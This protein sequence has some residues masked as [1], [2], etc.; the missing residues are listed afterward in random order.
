MELTIRRGT[1]EIGGTCIEISTAKTRLLV[2]FGMPLVNSK[3]EP[4]V[5]DNFK[6]F[7]VDELINQG[8][9]PNIQGAYSNQEPLVNGLLLSHAHADHF[10]L[11]HYLHPQIPVWLGEASHSILEINRIFLQR[12]TIIKNPNYFNS[13]KPFFIGDSKITPYLNDHSA[14]D[15]YSFLIEA[16]GKK[17]FYSGDFRGHGRKE[18][19]YRW[20]L[21]NTPKDVDY[22]LVEG[23]T[24]G[25]K[26]KNQL[27]EDD[28]EDELRS[29]F[30]KSE[31]INYIYTSSQNI[32]RLVSIYKA[33]SKAQKTFVVDIYTANV[34][35][36]LARFSKLPTPLKGFNNVKVLYPYR[37]TTKL[38]KQGLGDRA[39][40]F[41]SHKIQK[42]EISANP[43]KYV[44][45][46]R[47]SMD[48]DINKIDATHGNLIYS[49]WQGYKD[50]PST[51]R[52]LNML[53]S[54][55]FCIIDLHTS[56]HADISTLVEYADKIS[57]RVIIPIHTFYK[58]DYSSIFK[59][60]VL[61]LND[62]EV[63]TL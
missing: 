57:P 33:C 13:N 32:D 17:V 31:N 43:S 39:Y 41:K 28:L 61:E 24:V 22:L 47:P 51:K 11:M 18:K 45:L 60:K 1:N 8:I 42:S 5:F 55:N 12:E 30:Q 34:L 9:L 2:D 26:D 21:H 7:S 27:T 23:T 59:Q 29:I 3:R 50:Q 62:N 15:A 40:M 16:E 56:G 46:V 4:F 35:D 14:F 52:F 6:Q 63:V 54:K 38:I 53:Q 19:A 10:G 25:R 37:F 49:M 58:K 36:T 48:I 20:F 44:L